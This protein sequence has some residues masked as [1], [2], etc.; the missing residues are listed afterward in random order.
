MSGTAPISLAIIGLGRSGWN[1]HAA[2]VRDDARYRIASVFDPDAGRREEAER[3]LG[4][5]AYDDPGTMLESGE[6]EVVIV[7][8]PSHLHAAQTIQ[9]LES[10]R[11]V[12]VEKPMADTLP[13]VDRMIEAAAGADRQL[14]VHQNYR[15]KPDC[16]FFRRV[17][18]SGRLGE[19]FHIARVQHN[20]ARRNDWQCLKRYGGG[21]LNN[22]VIHPFDTI[23][24]LFDEPIEQVISDARHVSDAGDCED[25]AKLLLK[26]AGGRT[27][28][29]ELSTAAATKRR[30]PQWTFLGS[31]GALTL[32]GNTAELRWFDPAEAPPIE[33]NETPRV[34]ER[35]YGNQDQLP[36][37][38]ET[39]EIGPD[40]PDCQGPSFY[41]A[42]HQ[43]VR[44]G[45]PFP[46]RP[47]QVREIMRVISVAREQNPSFA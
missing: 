39:V 46:V 43:C 17:L 23:Y 8:S 22:H 13:D 33:V 5:T 40:H 25:H 19:V 21:L 2:A 29:L 7:A 45:A 27:I 36:W 15:F 1:I 35:K 32:D 41:D 34:A 20:F 10:G 18:E 44:H 9:A 14:M 38:E 28:D 47:A 24:S 11:H 37:Q 3:E 16:R 6:A 26:T 31:C 4:A 42:V 30:A 12:V